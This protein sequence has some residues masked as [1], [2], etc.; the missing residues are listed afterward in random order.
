[1]VLALVLRVSDSATGSFAACNAAVVGIETDETV[2]LVVDESSVVG[3]EF[4]SFC[5]DLVC[6]GEKDSVQKKGPAE[7]SRDV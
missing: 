1:M 3:S 5:L 4:S 2:V 6:L 7:T